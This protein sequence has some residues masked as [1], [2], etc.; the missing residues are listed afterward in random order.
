VSRTSTP[1][2][3][4]HQRVQAFHEWERRTHPLQM[5]KKLHQQMRL[6]RIAPF[7]HPLGQNEIGLC[8]DGENSVYPAT[9]SGMREALRDIEHAL[10]LVQNMGPEGT[11]T[12]GGHIFPKYIENQEMIGQVKR[13]INILDEKHPGWQ[14][15]VDLENLDVSSGYRCI[16]GQIFGSYELGIYDLFDIQWNNDAPDVVT[17]TEY[18]T[19]A[20]HGFVTSI[21]YHELEVV[22]KALL[23]EREA[24]MSTNEAPLLMAGD[25]V[26]PV[27][28]CVAAGQIGTVTDINAFG[29]NVIFDDTSVWTYAED[30]LQKMCPLCPDWD[31]CYPVGPDFFGGPCQI[32]GVACCEVCSNVH[33][34][35]HKEVADR[36]MFSRLRDVA[37]YVAVCPSLVFLILA[38]LKWIFFHWGH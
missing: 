31:E 12:M 25:R 17:D 32:D 20:H 37:W 18:H 30:M 27:D 1:T 35:T 23:A 5:W 4:A 2:S 9:A 26:R 36:S 8:L 10:P 19:I 34:V 16:L 6:H 24:S 38:L 7:A 22:W 3:E 33:A 29:I 14:T 15:H 11:Y 21:D 13:G 28:G